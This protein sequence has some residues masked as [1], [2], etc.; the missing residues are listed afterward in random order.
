[1]ISFDAIINSLKETI[2]LFDKKT[3][4]T[5][6]N[7]SGE[8]LLRKSSKDITGKKLLQIFNSEKTI[9]PLIKKTI[10]EGRSLRGKSAVLNIGHPINRLQPFTLFRKSRIQG[11]ILSI[12]E[13]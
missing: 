11:A 1:M 10:S 6:I 5:Y 9:S 2:I 7:K 3:N 8:E 12:S 4:I 13:K